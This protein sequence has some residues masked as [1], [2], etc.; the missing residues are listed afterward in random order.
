MYV[1]MVPTSAD[2]APGWTAAW[3]KCWCGIITHLHVLNGHHSL[4]WVRGEAEED[5]AMP[6]GTAACGAIFGREKQK[7]GGWKSGVLGRGQRKRPKWK[8]HKGYDMSRWRLSTDDL[9]PG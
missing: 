7:E 1:H 2:V 9:D 3:L 6:A 8:L 4:N 5:R